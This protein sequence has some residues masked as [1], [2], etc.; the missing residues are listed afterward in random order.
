MSYDVLLTDSAAIDL[1]ELDQFILSNDS[2]ESADYVLDKLDE[3]IGNLAE[4]PERGNYPPELFALGIQDYR[5]FFSS[6][7]E[8]SIVFWRIKSTFTS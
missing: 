4:F 6:H 3:V 8:L 5:E 7:I 1:E 2:V